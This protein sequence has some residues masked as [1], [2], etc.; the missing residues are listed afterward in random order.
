MRAAEC[1]PAYAHLF[2]RVKDDG[3]AD[4]ALIAFWAATQ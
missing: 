4:A 2:R 3:R 1:F